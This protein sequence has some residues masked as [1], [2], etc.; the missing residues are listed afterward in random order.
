MTFPFATMNF[1]QLVI[2]SRLARSFHHRWGQHR[3]ALLQHF[4]GKQVI[5]TEEITQHVRSLDE[6]ASL[7]DPG[8]SNNW[9]TMD[10]HGCVVHHSRTKRISWSIDPA[11]NISVQIFR[12]DCCVLQAE[13]VYDLGIYA[14]QELVI[15][16]TTDPQ[17]MI[18]NRHWLA[19]A[20]CLLPLVHR[21]SIPSITT[22]W[23]L[24]GKALQNLCIQINARQNSLKGKTNEAQR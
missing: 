2:A 13:L 24:L 6:S 15:L 5:S 12:S 1:K 20:Q 4:S 19:L 18:R 10:D 23:P 22:R 21:E 17:L 11:G 3:A 9:P 16:E 14:M 8:G 7:Q